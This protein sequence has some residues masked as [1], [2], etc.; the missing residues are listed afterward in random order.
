TSIGT[1]PPHDVVSSTFSVKNEALPVPPGSDPKEVVGPI[2]SIKNLALPSIASDEAREAV[3]PI[4]S[5]RN[6]ATG[7]GSGLPGT[8]QFS[9]TTFSALEGTVA[10]VTVTRSDGTNGTVTLSVTAANGTATAPGDFAAGSALLVFATGETTK[11]FDV[12]LAQDTL[13]EAP[14]TVVLTLSGPTGA[15]LGAITT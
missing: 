7:P 6:S 9:A 13:S 10:H 11:T 5:V 8:L 4:F 3:G 1:I 14:E 2:F 12:S 15:S